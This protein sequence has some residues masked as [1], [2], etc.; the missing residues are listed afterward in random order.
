MGAVE[1]ADRKLY[2]GACLLL[3]FKFNQNGEPHVVR[4]LCAL[5][6]Q[7]DRS[8]SS[9]PLCHAEFKVSARKERWHRTSA[10]CFSVGGSS[11]R[12]LACWDAGK[13]TVMT[14]SRFSY[15]LSPGAATEAPEVVERGSLHIPLHSKSLLTGGAEVLL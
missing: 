6:K 4:N 1:K 8:L 11:R 13:A 15:G 3:A 5:I 2:A 7:M 10:R 12:W 14:V 9:Q